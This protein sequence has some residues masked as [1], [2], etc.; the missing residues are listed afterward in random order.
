MKIY[1]FFLCHF[2]NTKAWS[3][4]KYFVA[5][6]CYNINL[7]IGDNRYGENGHILKIAEM[8]YLNY[9]PTIT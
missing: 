7:M 5:L 4:E 2:K 9:K 1:K 3:L 8:K 6:L